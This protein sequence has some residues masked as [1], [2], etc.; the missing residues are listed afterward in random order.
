MLSLFLCSCT[1]DELKFRGE[2]DYS[3]SERE[4]A[5]NKFGTE[6]KKIIYQS[7]NKNKSYFIGGSVYHD[8]DIFNHVTTTH[9]FGH[10]GIEF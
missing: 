2:F 4:T 10:L 3:R 5:K 9:G 6:F 8:Y 7:P 1:M